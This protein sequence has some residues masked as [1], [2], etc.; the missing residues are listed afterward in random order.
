MVGK[1]ADSNR[2]YLI[3]FGLATTATAA[4][5]SELANPPLPPVGA[6]GAGG[7][8]GAGTGTG[9]GPAWSPAKVVGSVRYMSVR[10]HLGLKAGWACDLE[11][12]VYVLL[13]L[14]RGT[15]PWQGCKV[16]EPPSPRAYA[17]ASVLGMT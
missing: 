6:P 10:A 9:Q 13:Y 16:G 12:V 2:L 8:G 4:S 14:F 7:G 17:H 11:S 3:D 1:G 15:L 5:A